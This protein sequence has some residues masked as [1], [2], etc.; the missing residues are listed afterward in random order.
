MPKIQPPSPKVEEVEMV[1]IIFCAVIIA[2]LCLGQSVEEKKE[3]ELRNDGYTKYLAL[4]IFGGKRFTY[5][6]YIEFSGIGSPWTEVSYPQLPYSLWQGGISTEYQFIPHLSFSLDGSYS[7][8]KNLSFFC[9]AIIVPPVFKFTLT[10]ASFTILYDNRILR[11]I[12]Y[13]VGAGVGFFYIELFGDDVG[14]NNNDTIVN[15]IC[16]TP[17]VKGS[18]QLN[19]ASPLYLKIQLESNFHHFIKTG[20][21]CFHLDKCFPTI[22]AGMGYRFNLEWRKQ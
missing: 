10:N 19:I 17:M 4:E 2:G 6:H 20:A 9:Y 14:I 8:T 22:S 16:L 3:P 1:K 21:E 7:S 12:G 5:Y 15:A 13:Q 11:V 18:L